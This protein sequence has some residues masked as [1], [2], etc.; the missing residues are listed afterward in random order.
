[1]ESD[2]HHPISET[3]FLILLSISA[4]PT[5]GYAVMKD[6]CDLSQEQV[7]L[8]TGTLYGALKRLLDF[9]W[10]KRTEESEPT[11]DQ[12]ERKSY[13]LTSQG[14]RVLEAEVNRLGHLVTLARQRASQEQA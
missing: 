3:T 4:G 14:K 2:A 11:T 7:I 6:V 10:I 5:H 9:G 13:V 1:M 8:S 12:R